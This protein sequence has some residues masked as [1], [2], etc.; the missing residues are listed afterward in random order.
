[1][2]PPPFAYAVARTVEDAVAMLDAEGTGARVLAGG[3]SLLPL[4]RLRQ[5]APS[6]LVDIARIDK[7][8]HL[9]VTDGELRVGACVTQAALEGWAR[10]HSLDVIAEAAPHVGHAAIRNLGTVVGSLAHADPAAEWPA[11][12]LALEGSCEVVGPQGARTIEVAELFSGSHTTVLAPAEVITSVRLPVP[13]PTW[14]SAFE[15]VAPR[16]GDP[17]VAA[18]AVVL[19]TSSD[20]I[21]EARI[22]LCGVAPTPIRS[23]AAEAVLRGADLSD[24]VLEQAA[25]RVQ[26]DIAPIGDL[27]GSESYRRRVASVAVLRALRRAIARARQEAE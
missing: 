21:D 11:V 15:E 4:L 25:D 16:R 8:R 10:Q 20:A 17:A 13:P 9:E 7:L 26:H 23:A 3:Q 14:C 2:K 27:H 18:A 1:M 24:D 6:L 5:T 12:A 22:A 19:A